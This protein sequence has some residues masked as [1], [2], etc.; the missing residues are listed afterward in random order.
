[1]YTN[2]PVRDFAKY[3]S[4]NVLGMLGLSCYILAD[5]FFISKGLGA[6]GLTALNL[7]IPIYSFVHGTGLMLGMGGAT[8]YAI[9]RS[10][11][12]GGCNKIFTNTV[13]FAGVFA[14]FFVLA[15]LF[16]S[17]QIAALLGADSDVF[18]MTSTYLRV[19]LLFSPAFLLNNVLLCF[20]RNDGKPQLSML[21]MLGGSFSNIILDYIFIF[22]L[23]MG[24]FGAVLATG[25]APIISMAILSPHL[26][27]QS[28][29]FTLEP[30]SP[31]L[32]MLGSTASLGLPSLIT[33]VSSG[34]V[35]MVFNGII[36]SLQGNVG[37]AAYGIIANLSLVVI[38]IYTGIAQGIQPL[39]SRAHGY[40]DEKGAALF[41][42]YA[43][44]AMAVI[45]CIIYLAVIFFAHPLARIFNSENNQQ[46][47]DIA[48]LGLKLYFTG[49]IFAGFNIIL[50][51][52]FTS[53]ERE[54]PAHLIAL[55]RGFF[56]IIPASFLLSAIWGMIGVWLAFPVAECLVAF[57]G[58]FFL[59]RYRKSLNR[60]D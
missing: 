27:S 12:E 31:S 47:Q 13:T 8:K 38:A 22:P 44:A 23:N 14:L 41:L 58:L 17:P 16:F 48:V 56:L 34:I 37:V 40:Q 3:A 28:R 52:F 59:L 50:A 15:G 21:G 45:S 33:E 30:C 36:L 49:C 20:V 29:G 53:S 60:K 51:V 6:N 19:V 55:L 5:T 39:I 18:D 7:A 26:L 25:L 46:L 10:Q 11:G 1:M 32:S 24:I 9:L 35:I 2:S 42:H 54:R 4:L 57:V 43:I